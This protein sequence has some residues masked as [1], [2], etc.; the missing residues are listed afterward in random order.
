MQAAKERA[1]R[2]R[3]IAHTEPEDEDIPI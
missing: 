1:D 3:A 2:I